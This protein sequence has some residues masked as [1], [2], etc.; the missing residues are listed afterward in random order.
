MLPKPEE[1]AYVAGFVDGEGCFSIG[2]NG[3]VSLGIVNT[4][5]CT[6]EFVLKV[7]GAGVIQ[8]RKQKVNKR[9]YIFRSYGENCMDAVHLLLPYLI[10]KRDQALLLIEYRN[11][12]G[13]IRVPGLKGAR[14]NPDRM[15]YSQRMKELKKNEQ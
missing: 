7:L 2:K 10:E 3:S 5:R 13:S 8:D 4:S 12:P 9:Q 15:G 1:L 6:L 11:I 14:P